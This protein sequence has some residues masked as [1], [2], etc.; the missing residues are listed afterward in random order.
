VNNTYSDA[1][2]VSTGVPQGSVL[3]PILFLVYVNDIANCVNH[4]KVRLFADDTNL[5]FSDKSVNQ[6]QSH[7]NE[8]LDQLS[9]WFSA[10]KL[11]LNTDKTCY[12]IFSNSKKAPLVNLLLNGS[13]IE[14]VKESKYLG[15]YLDEKLN[16]KYNIAHI[17]S[18]LNQLSG[19]FR[20]LADYIKPDNIRQIYYAYVFPY[21]KY[22]IEVYGSCDQSILK[23]LQTA[24]NKLLK[25]LCKK[26]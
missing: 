18:K 9:K 16:W 21:I 24:Q 14:Y 12:T 17:C 6:L 4:G 5:F 8:A 19:A 23:P 13:S 11:T 15:M 3:G 10:N 7:A 25:I 26:S 2:P 1:Y 20:Y 22:G